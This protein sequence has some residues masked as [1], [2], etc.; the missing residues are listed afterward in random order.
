LPLQQ[1]KSELCA[2]INE[3]IFTRLSS[4]R[5]A[6]GLIIDKKRQSDLYNKK[7]LVESF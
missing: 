3:G 1:P 7:G 4:K 5:A 6:I 2:G